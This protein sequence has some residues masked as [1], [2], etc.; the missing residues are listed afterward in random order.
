[1]KNYKELLKYSKTLSILYV[2][3][4]ESLRLSTHDIL[5]HYFD[6]VY[7]AKDG[8]EALEYYDKYHF[9]LILTDISMPRMDGVE[10]IEKIYEKNPSQVILVISA[11]EESDYLLPLINLGVQRFVRKPLDIEELTGALIVASKKILQDRERK[12]SN[13]QVILE[14]TDK[15][16][17]AKKN[18]SLHDN[19]ENIYLTKYEMMFLNLLSTEVG[20]IYSNEDIVSYYKSLDSTIDGDNIRKLVSKLRKKLSE[21]IIESIYA[22]GY[23]LISF[24]EKLQV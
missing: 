6:V 18:M 23:R 24:R 7:S 5:K 2:E 1:M 21:N 22:V 12:N 4:H 17:Y 3:D 13:Q 15:V 10:L 16:Y 20:K 8:L 9:D 11:H 14:F 19:G